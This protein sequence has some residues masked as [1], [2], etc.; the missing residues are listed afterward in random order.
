[1]EIGLD[2][3]IQ[4]FYRAGCIGSC[5]D[6][7]LRQK[8]RQRFRRGCRRKLSIDSVSLCERSA[9]KEHDGKTLM[10]KCCQLI[11]DLGGDGFLVGKNENAVGFSSGRDQFAADH[12]RMQQH[13][14]I[15]VVVVI[16]GSHHAGGNFRF[17]RGGIDGIVGEQAAIERHGHDRC[18][19][20]RDILHARD[21]FI[22]ARKIGPEGLC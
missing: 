14:G 7:F 5:M 22:Q 17:R 20:L 12:L 13:V 16:A 3:G 21:V 4:N 18:A 11:G 2:V 8:F 19:G 9:A 10:G 1:M 6:I 15:D